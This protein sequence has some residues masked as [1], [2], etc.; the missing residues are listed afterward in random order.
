MNVNEVNYL[1]KAVDRIYGDNNG[2]IDKQKEVLIFN[3]QL[4]YHAK[5]DTKTLEENLIFSRWGKEQALE[6]LQTK[7][8]VSSNIESYCCML[9]LLP[10]SI[11]T[12]LY[13]V[14]VVS[15]TII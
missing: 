6:I 13:D 14:S 8:C 3:E 10:N 5:G 2:Q 15:T 9:P 7:E 11:G 1:K 4:S 12:G